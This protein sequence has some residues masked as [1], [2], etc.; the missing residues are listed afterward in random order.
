MDYI[1]L[2]SV[3]KLTAYIYWNRKP[4]NA[5]EECSENVLFTLFALLGLNPTHIIQICSFLGGW[6]DK[7]RTQMDYSLLL[8]LRHRL[9]LIMA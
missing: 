3:S 7:T 1:G 6:V 2:E 8:G 9:R 4:L 5:Y